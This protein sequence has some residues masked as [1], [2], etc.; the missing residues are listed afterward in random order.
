MNMNETGMRH[1]DTEATKFKFNILESL[2]YFQVSVIILDF[3][4]INDFCVNVCVFFL[5]LSFLA[6][7]SLAASWGRCITRSS[8]GSIWAFWGFGIL[9]KGTSG[10]KVYWSSLT[11][12]Q[13]FARN[14]SCLGLE[15]R[16]L[17]SSRFN[18]TKTYLCCWSRTPV[19]SFL[20][21]F[22]ICD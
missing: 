9:L 12:I 4:C 18:K 15:P 10:V 16:A 6:A 13:S 19:R 11:R 7:L 21:N 3:F 20:E 5:S 14:F 17:V 2:L 1:K 8:Q 22:W